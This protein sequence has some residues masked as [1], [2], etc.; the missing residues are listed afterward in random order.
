MQ[1]PLFYRFLGVFLI[2][3]SNRK[4]CVENIDSPPPI[5]SQARDS[6]PLVFVGVLSPIDN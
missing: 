4:T 3:Y 1:K 6:S 5:D 2:D